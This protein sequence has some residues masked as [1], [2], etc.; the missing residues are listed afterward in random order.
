MTA[1]SALDIAAAD[2]GYYAPADPEP[3]SA[4]ARWLADKLNQP[5]LRG[6]STRI[7]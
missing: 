6:P 1:Q 4:A 2:I 7:W 5:S 3:G